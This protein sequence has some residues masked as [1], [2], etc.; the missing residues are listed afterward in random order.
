MSEEKPAISVKRFEDFIQAVS[1]AVNLPTS[2]SSPAFTLII[3]AGFSNGLIPTAYD[4]AFHD[5]PWWLDPER[6][7]AKPFSRA[8]GCVPGSD[9][10]FQKRRNALWRK[11]KEEQ[12][13][14]EK[15]PPDLEVDGDGCPVNNPD[16][17]A[18][19]YKAIM[20][21]SCGLS[22]QE[23]RCNYLRDAVKRTE[24]EI[25]YAHLFLAG[26]LEAQR[27]EAW[28]KEYRHR[29][30]FCRTVLTTN[31]DTLLQRSLQLNNQLFFISDQPDKL[32]DSLDDEHEAVHVVQ[33]HGSIF[34]RFT[35][36]DDEEI[37]RMMEKNAPAF[38]DYLGRHGVI[39]IG[40]GGWD[41]TI[42]KALEK[43][44]RFEG[45]LYWC[46]ITPEGEWG[47][48]C[49]KVQKLLEDHSGD[50]YYVP[51][52]GNDG[53]FVTMRELHKALG[54]KNHPKVLIDPFAN[55]LESIRGFRFQ[56]EYEYENVLPE[57]QRREV[58]PQCLADI[59]KP[60]AVKEG[61]IK[62]LSKYRDRFNNP[63]TYE[64]KRVLADSLTL[65]GDYSSARAIYSSLIVMDGVT[66]DQRAWALF[67]R[68]MLINDE[69]E[70]EAKIGDLLQVTQMADISSEIKLNA[71]YYRGLTHYFNQNNQDAIKDFTSAID[72]FDQP[73]EVK[74]RS[75]FFRAEVY[76]KLK[77][78]VSATSD[79]TVALLQKELPEILNKKAVDALGHL[80]YES[81]RPCPKE[82]KRND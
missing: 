62:L 11:I 23:A 54:L 74:A 22:S 27:T 24:N 81:H 29:R 39:V 10:E 51:L 28:K 42:M 45:N 19:C 72:L 78:Y 16:N 5:I 8:P 48:L 7:A 79:Y 4:M 32:F 40:Y 82:N 6:D 35:A 15:I 67:L 21:A 63:E 64:E 18:R 80:E 70:Y 43:C 65:A 55:L 30:P 38:T 34:R 53:A 20:C 46:G 52:K 12:P 13:R 61:V 57:K 37:R 49:K 17:I 76:K 77:D 41:D 56:P 33:T 25:N 73:S 36:N 60:Q 26:I 58:S 75:F 59:I 66:S 1:T 9:P 69:T 31:F 68:A 2:D 14:N 47:G 71:F 50:A 44:T 3:G